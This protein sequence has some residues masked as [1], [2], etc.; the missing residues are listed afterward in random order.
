MD[1]RDIVGSIGPVVILFKVGE[2]FY[3]YKSGIYLDPTCGKD[4][5]HAMLLVGFGKDSATGLEYW[6]VKNSW[7][8]LNLFSNLS[9][10]SLKY[11]HQE[12]HGV[13]M[14]M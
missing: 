14:V 12:H 8:E 3:N 7:G 6:T 11:L 9:S 1:F 2:T 5:N 13:T 10:Y 4:V